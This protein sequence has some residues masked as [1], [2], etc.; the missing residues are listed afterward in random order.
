MQVG[1]Q[2][3]RNTNEFTGQVTWPGQSRSTN[4][5][6]PGAST[7]GWK[8]SQGPPLPRSAE[9]RHT[10][11]C[12][13]KHQLMEYTKG[14][15]PAGHPEAAQGGRKQLARREG[16][17]ADLTTGTAEPF[18][19]CVHQLLVWASCLPGTACQIRA[20]TRVY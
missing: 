15:E 19:K 1:R 9:H 2:R 11:V 12:V 13:C 14:Q 4:H 8:R 17:W 6:A 5:Q 20:K 3:K 10:P 7:E 16:I 18:R